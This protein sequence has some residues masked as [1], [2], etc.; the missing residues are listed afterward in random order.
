MS[1]G[2]H[3]TS[4]LILEKIGINKILK[5]I[6]GNKTD[7][8]KA[9]ANYYL[10]D[11][12]NTI[13]GFKYW[14]FKNYAGL[15]KIYSESYISDLLNNQ[16]TTE[17][18]YKFQSEWYKTYKK[19]NNE[20][21]K[22]SYINVDSTNISS[23]SQNIEKAEYG[24]SKNKENEPI[25][26][27]GLITDQNNGFPIYYDIYSGSITDMA[28]CEILV[29]KAKQLG[30]KEQTLVMDR[31]YFSSKNISFLEQNNFKFIM[32]AKLWN[33]NLQKALDENKDFLKHN[34]NML[35]DDNETFATTIKGKVFT[36]NP[37][38]FNI[39]LIHNPTKET[40]RVSYYT[41]YF[42]KMV[43]QVKQ[44][45]KI[46][47]HIIESYE[48]YLDIEQDESGKLISVKPNNKSFHKHIQ[49][50]GFYAI[51]SNT[52]KDTK[53]IIKA[54]RKRDSIEKMFKWIKTQTNF[55]KNYSYNDGVL[56][57]KTFIT[58]IS[59]IIKSFITFHCSEL[60]K[61]KSTLTFNSILGELS[62]IEVTNIDGKYVRKNSLTAKQKE[63][64]NCLN[65]SSEELYKSIISINEKLS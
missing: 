61:K 55:N 5:D 57:S 48:D 52:N 38:E 1:F 30:I 2:L 63:I 37:K 50:A 42:T 33:K 22:E 26:N 36:D 7:L 44:L 43:N 25:I 64:L 12:N 16:L 29:E 58:F 65:I 31:G 41:K 20:N 24:Y 39:V 3:S 47:P 62:K 45:K 6:F 34:I 53:E 18:I 35:I 27:I 15:E 32:M 19:L 23:T 8:I 54:Y 60:I 9:L 49:N 21:I 13:Q 4:E 28:Q 11:G 14:L 56:E 51:I 46:K 10:S 17:K 59:S 40:E